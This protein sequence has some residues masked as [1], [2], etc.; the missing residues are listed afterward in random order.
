MSKSSSYHSC[1]YYGFHCICVMIIIN[2]CHDK[3]LTSMFIYIF[4]STQD[5]GL[6]PSVAASS[7]KALR[8]RYT[9]LPYLYTLHFLA[10][11]TGSTVV[12]PLFF[13]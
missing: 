9:L 7:R 12:R 6:W 10:A 2:I 8:I 13:E 4:V 1:Y 3:I 5:P 11:T